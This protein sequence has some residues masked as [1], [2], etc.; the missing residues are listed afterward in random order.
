MSAF[1][2]V[3]KSVKEWEPEPQANELSYRNALMA[4]LGQH[5]RN[6]K[7]IE[8]EYR[9]LG[10]TTDIYIKQSGFWGDSEVFVELKRNLVSKTQLDRLV[11][12]IELLEPKKHAIVIVLC[13]E[14]NAAL[15]ARLSEKYGTPEGV[16]RV[17][18]FEIVIKTIVPSKTNA[19]KVTDPKPLKAGNRKEVLAT[20]DLHKRKIRETRIVNNLYP[21][22]RRLRESFLQHDLADRSDANR[23]FFD[24]WLADPVVEM[25][26]S[27]A[28]GW[29]QKRVAE[30]HNDLESIRV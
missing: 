20:I 5:L 24:K 7:R 2:G 26:W 29:T 25:G 18:Y 6:V 21:E 14:T 11:G 30:L 22:L 8:S 27:P 15:V 23:K 12:Q 3:L 28:G 10:T 4:H 19:S 1:D 13:G 16:M 17:T 9:H